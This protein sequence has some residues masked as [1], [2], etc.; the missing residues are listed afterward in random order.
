MFSINLSRKQE[1][2]NQHAGQSPCHR[3]NSFNEHWDLSHKVTNMS[4]VSE[5]SVALMMVVRFFYLQ[6]VVPPVRHVSVERPMLVERV[7]S[8]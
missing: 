7:L 4:K 1:A 6:L 3:I 8:M 5:V 2:Y